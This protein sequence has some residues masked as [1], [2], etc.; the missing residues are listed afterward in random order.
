MKTLG[1]VLAGGKSKR[2]GT[3]KATLKI[4]DQTM[5]ELA[6]DRLLQTSI[7]D[8][9]ISRNDGLSNHISDII[10]NKGP[11]SGIHSAAHRF[12][13]YNLLILPVDVP[14]ISHKSLQNVIDYGVKYNTNVALKGSHLPL[15]LKNSKALRFVLDY[16]LKMTNH[17][18]VE[19]FCQHFPLKTLP[20][21][22]ENELLNANHPAQWQLA[23][24]L[25]QKQL[26]PIQSEYSNGA[27]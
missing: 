18:S 21:N 17:Y 20:I 14:L 22:N 9:V 15:F 6:C 13:N 27:F 8:V 5:L 16:T 26:N 3:D 12:L 23:T 10:A 1:V 11:L 7:E 19:R 25:H 2:M 24:A 4:G